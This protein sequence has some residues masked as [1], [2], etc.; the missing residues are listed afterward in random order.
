MTTYTKK[1]ELQSDLSKLR[2]MGQTIGFVPTMGALHDGHM[3]LVREANRQCD[4]VLVSVFVNPAQF[5]NPN[6]L[7]T[8]PRQLDADMAL[9]S[10][11]AAGALVFTPEVEEVYPQNEVLN[12]YNLSHLDSV[13]E[14]AKRPGH[15]QGVAAVVDR[16]FCV[17]GPCTAFFGEKDFQQ[18][19]IIRH[20]AKLFHP[21]VSVVG[22]PTRR[23]SD[24]LAMSS[25]NML[26]SPTQR[27]AV[28]VIYESLL[29]FARNINGLS[30]DQCKQDYIQRVEHCGTLRVE[31][32]E[33]AEMLNLQPTN[34]PSSDCRLFTAVYAG[35]V[36]LID[37]VPL[38]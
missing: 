17:T 16:F 29:R 33:L 9:L 14:G 3:S 23:E 13:M 20:V 32:I 4:V 35:D 26:L 24:G 18:L 6:D 15:F 2:G 22:V 10:K 21:Q 12:R 30:V 28:S 7:T 31:Y 8:Y 34:N 5:N 38:S 19:A 36:R 25:R 11:N 27:S 37:N 1:S